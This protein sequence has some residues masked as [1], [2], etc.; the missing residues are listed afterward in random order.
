MDIWTETFYHYDCQINNSQGYVWKTMEVEKLECVLRV[1]VV[2]KEEGS[3]A[4]EGS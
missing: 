3:D 4:M 2:I 1:M